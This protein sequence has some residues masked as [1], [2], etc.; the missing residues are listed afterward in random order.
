MSYQ[1]TYEAWLAD[2]D[3]EEELRTELEA[4]AGDEEAIRERFYKE[5]E[6]GTGG[7]RGVMGAGLNRMNRYT[8]QK[9]TAGFAAYLLNKYHRTAM[10]RGVVIAYDSRKHSR[11]FA[12]EAALVLTAYGIRVQIFEKLTPTPVLSFAVRHLKAVGG[13]VITASHN[14]QEYNGYKVYDEYGCQ[15]VPDAAEALLRE[16]ERFQKPED[17]PIIMSQELVEDDGLLRWLDDQVLE[18]FLEAVQSQSLYTDAEA[19]KA[20]KIV[21][22]PLHGTGREPVLR[23]LAQ[24]GFT[25]VELVSAQA[26]PDGAFATVRSPNPEEREALALAI[27]CAE[28][29][30]ADLVVGTDPDCDRVGAAVKTEAGYQLLNG[31]QVGALLLDFVLRQKRA[32]LDE[33][34]IV[35]K[36]IVT[37]DLGAEIAKNYGVK[38]LETLTGFKFIGQKMTQFQLSGSHEFIMGYEESYGYLV[39]GH[40]RDKD[41]VVAAMLIAEMAAYYK[42]QGKT[43]SDALEGLYQAYGYYVDEVQSFTLEGISGQE[44][45]GQIMQ[46]LRAQGP[47]TIGGLTVAQ[48]KDYRQGVDELPPADVLKYV[49]AEG[50]WMAVRPSGTEPKIKFYYS[51]PGCDAAQ[52]HARVEALK[53]FAAAS[54]GQ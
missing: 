33:R 43:L 6:F 39:G 30:G 37:S 47:D 15:L 12:L 16:I 24:D 49:F 22:T 4:I 7:M 36:S 21:Y 27:S 11:D 9:A 45:I 17:I 2:P 48:Y 3:L 32:Q 40:A 44:R 54:V 42:A 50:G 53:A 25:A 10:E 18:A 29:N 23:A 8:I 35:I 13:I 28:M 14:T 20:L 1:K 31:N 5:L 46:M 26:E 51:L 19:K 34:S 41:A 52:A 38:M